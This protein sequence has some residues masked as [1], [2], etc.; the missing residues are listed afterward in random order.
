MQLMILV[1][2]TTKV[3][4]PNQGSSIWLGSCHMRKKLIISLFKIVF[5]I[6]IYISITNCYFKVK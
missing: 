3:I 6:Y 5:Y 4:K 1:L 2:S